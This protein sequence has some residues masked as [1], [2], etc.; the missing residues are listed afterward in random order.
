DRA[1]RLRPRRVERA[2]AER[3]L[4]RPLLRGGREHGG[5]DVH[6]LRRAAQDLTAAL[7]LVVA[8]E[9]GVAEAPHGVDDRE[10]GLALL[11][12]L[13]LDARRRLRIAVPLDDPLLLERA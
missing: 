7:V 8:G 6:R 12:Q 1:H 2:L 10:E 11:G 13:V 5:G 9:P 4:P 3:A